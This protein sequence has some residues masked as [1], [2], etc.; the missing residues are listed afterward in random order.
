MSDTNNIDRNN[1][2]IFVIKSYEAEYESDFSSLLI[3]GE[4][5][6]SLKEVLKSRDKLLKS[7][8]K[9]SGLKIKRTSQRKTGYELESTLLKDFSFSEQSIVLNLEY[10]KS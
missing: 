3:K 7:L 2:F 8:E 4:L 1:R 10:L 6:E 9:D 5:K